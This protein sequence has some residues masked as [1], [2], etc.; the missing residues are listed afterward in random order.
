ME[1]TYCSIPQYVALSFVD[2]IL[3]HKCKSAL[4][5][6]LCTGR[7]DLRFVTQVIRKEVLDVR[8][9]EAIPLETIDK[10]GEVRVS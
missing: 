2:I 5:R 10:E 3:L 8:C 9:T 6:Y 4:F 7:A 1:S